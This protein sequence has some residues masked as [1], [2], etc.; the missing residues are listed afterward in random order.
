MTDMKNYVIYQIAKSIFFPT[1]IKNV[2]LITS[3]VK[4]KEIYQKN[5][6]I[7]LSKKCMHLW[8]YNKKL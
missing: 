3:Q 8:I 2:C 4:E 1:N 5:K 6:L 7:N